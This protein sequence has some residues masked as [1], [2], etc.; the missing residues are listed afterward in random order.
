M[1]ALLDAK[2]LEVRDASRGW[3]EWQFT[4]A[5]GKKIVWPD[6]VKKAKGKTKSK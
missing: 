6:Y 1:K 5:E 3:P 4:G 2:Y